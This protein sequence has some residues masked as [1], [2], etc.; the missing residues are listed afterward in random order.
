MEIVKKVPTRV[1][2]LSNLFTGG[3]VINEMSEDIWCILIWF[4][5]CIRD[6]LFASKEMFDSLTICFS[7]FEHPRVVRVHVD[8]M[9]L[10]TTI[11]FVELST[12]TILRG[13]DLIN[14]SL[15][16]HDLLLNTGWWRGDNFVS[17]L[18][19]PA[20][21]HIFTV[22]AHSESVRSCSNWVDDIK[23]VLARSDWPYSV[24]GSIY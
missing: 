6:L 18:L 23:V 24:P 4:H 12:K 19:I 20:G 15:S 8:V 2:L 3:R 7:N 9:S 16:L 14:V 1:T 21:E 5:I 17:S 11:P 13:P 22:G 10:K